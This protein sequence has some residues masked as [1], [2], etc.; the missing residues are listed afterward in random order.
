[1]SSQSTTVRPAGETV[2]NSGLRRTQYNSSVPTGFWVGHL[3]L[4][5]APYFPVF[6]LIPQPLYFPHIEL[7]LS[8]EFF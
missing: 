8:N 3:I 7:K 2:C 5:L 4:K 6:F 1:M